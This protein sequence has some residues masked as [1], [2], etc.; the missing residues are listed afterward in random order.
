MVIDIHTHCMQPDHVSEAAKAADERAGYPSMLPLSPETYLK[1]ME[2]VDR[3]IVFGIRAYATGVESPNNATAEWIRNAPN[4][5]IGFTAIDPV[6]QACL[7]EIDRGVE[8]GLRGI[9]IY[10]MLGRYNPI[11]PTIFAVYEKAQR[12]RLPIL[13]HF[14]AHP[15]PRAM[16]KYSH[17]ILVDEIAQAFPDLKFVIA[18]MAHPWQRDCALVLRKHPNVFADVSG[19]GWVRPWQAWQAFV[20][21]QEWGVTDKLLFG[22]DFPLWSPAEGM[23]K[24]RRLNEQVDGTNLPRIREE[25]IEGIINRN[26]LELLGL[27]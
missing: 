8:L 6:D 17:P 18:H 11:D 25:V 3:A 22:S 19:S 1:A 16:L 23:E 15:N 9:K 26:S 13:S 21:M 20:L 24:M 2:P 14:G 10:P 12:L 27:E 7:E 5:L 4:K